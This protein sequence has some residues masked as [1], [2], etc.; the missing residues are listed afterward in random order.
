M[1]DC[2]QVLGMYLTLA[3]PA[4]YGCSSHLQSGAV[5]M[6]ADKF[7]MRHFL[8]YYALSEADKLQDQSISYSLWPGRGSSV[9]EPS[10]LPRLGSKREA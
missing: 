4:R 5:L 1:S 3:V 7:P 8:N 2:L 6:L 9:K 10:S